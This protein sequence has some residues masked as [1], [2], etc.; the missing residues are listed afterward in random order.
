LTTI[1]I[2]IGNC[3]P[4]DEENNFLA[5]K[6]P[7]YNDDLNEMETYKNLKTTT[8]N[9]LQEKRELKTLEI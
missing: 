6:I 9:D 3:S 5:H 4:S 8:I 2:K 1:R 7:I